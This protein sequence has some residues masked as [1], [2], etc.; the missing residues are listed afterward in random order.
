M[1]AQLDLLTIQRQHETKHGAKL[2][3]LRPVVERVG[4]LAGPAGFTVENIRRAAK[5]KGTGRE[6][7]WLGALASYYGLVN[8][9]RRRYGANR[10]PSV[11]WVLP[12]YAREA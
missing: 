5:L 9:G 12:C 1:T 10:N 11:V 6:L 4:R 8:T 3:A 7:S 2:E